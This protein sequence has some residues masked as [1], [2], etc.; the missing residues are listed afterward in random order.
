MN[1][2]LNFNKVLCISPHPDD[3]EYSMGGSI[4]KCKDTLF[5]VLCLSNGG[6]YDITSN[7]TRIK[8]TQN[9][10]KIVKCYNVKLLNTDVVF[11]NEKR[12][13]EWINYIE[14]KM[15]NMEE[16]NCVFCPTS[17]DSHFE[18]RFTFGLAN[19]LIR[20]IPV[21]LIEY[22]TPSTL[23]S[24]VANLLVDISSV[25]DNKIRMLKEFKSQKHKSFF[26]KNS[27]NSFHSHYQASKRKIKTIEKFNIKVNYIL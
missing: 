23:D 15:V 26:H 2:F 6:D 17:N 27:L 18:H 14:T 11:M 7:K 5:D 21:S 25:Y 20:S 19:A 1:K 24:W 4:I 9:S 13:D 10:W 3:V 8:E 16:Y 12:E 22:F